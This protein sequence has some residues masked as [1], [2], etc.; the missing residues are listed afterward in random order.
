MEK[1]IYFLS[2]AD[3]RLQKSLKRIK[4]QAKEIGVFDKIYCWDERNLDKSF[5]KKW[6]NFCRT[7]RGFG[8]WIYKPQM[9][10]QVFEEMQDGDIL[11]YCDAGCH[12]HKCG[13]MRQLQYFDMLEQSESGI[14]AFDQEGCIEK[15]WTKGDLFDYFSVR[16]NS[17]ITES[18]IYCGG[19]FIMRKCK[20][21]IDFVNKWISVWY[22]NIRLLDDSPS[23]SPNFED[24]K[25]HRHDQS[26]FSILCKINNVPVIASYETWPPYPIAAARDLKWYVP[27]W[28]RV[29][30][31]LKNYFQK[32]KSYNAE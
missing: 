19:I 18:N 13:K 1:Q 30:K 8:F 25:E 5:W 9:V 15:E 6:G 10:L 28:K 16:L 7:N 3:R 4:K 31:K 29:A 32:N 2:F 22:N 21:S 23:I 14:I 11:Q 20:K 24:F 17:D 12:I 26:V 27:L